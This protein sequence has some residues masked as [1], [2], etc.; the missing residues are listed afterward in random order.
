ME[1]L[2]VSVAA[3]ASSRGGAQA[4]VLDAILNCHIRLRHSPCE[5]LRL[6][7]RAAIWT[8]SAI[9]RIRR[10]CCL[11]FAFPEV[12]ASETV[13]RTTGAKLFF[14]LQ[15]RLAGGVRGDPGRPAGRPG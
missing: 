6:R 4:T 5:L 1:G 11:P 14:R 15:K 7:G 3:P 8:R 10:Y 2:S 13:A 9:P 12:I